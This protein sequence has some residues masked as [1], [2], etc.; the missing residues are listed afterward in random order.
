MCTAS[1]SVGSFQLEDMEKGVV[2]AVDGYVKSVVR[3]RIVAKKSMVS[4]ISRC[5]VFI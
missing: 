3:K 2:D 4:Y 5:V 1:I